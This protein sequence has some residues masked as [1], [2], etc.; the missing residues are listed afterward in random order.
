MFYRQG[1]LHTPN[2][3]WEKKVANL[4]FNTLCSRSIFPGICKRLIYFD[5]LQATSGLKSI[6]IACLHIKIQL[7]TSYHT[8]CLGVLFV[9]VL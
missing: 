9:I 5:T 7:L 8:L 1:I 4:F 3:V 2:N 6:S